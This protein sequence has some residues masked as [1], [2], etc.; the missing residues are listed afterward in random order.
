MD[1]DA[2]GR[3][4]LVIFGAIKQ[5]IGLPSSVYVYIANVADGASVANEPVHQ[6]LETYEEPMP[7]W[8]AM[9]LAVVLV[10]ISQVKINV[11]NA[12][13]VRSRGRTPTPG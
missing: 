12:Y 11:T 13:P 1:H 3:A 8:L 9:A 7:G 6:F 10:V 2:A 5:V 4:G